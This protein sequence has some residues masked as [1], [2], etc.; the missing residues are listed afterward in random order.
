MA[1]VNKIA[2][3]VLAATT[4]IAT[5]AVGMIA[6]GSAM[7]SPSDAATI[8]VNGSVSG[9][10]FTAYKLAS[11]NNVTITDGK[12]QA[13]VASEANVKG[14]IAA[15]AKEANIKV[16]DGQDPVDAVARNA[17][18]TQVKA[19]AAAL[20]KA[21]L[22]SAGTADGKGSTATLNVTEGWYLVTDSKGLPILVG[23]KIKSGNQTATAMKDGTPLGTVNIKSTSL[24]VDKKVNGSDNGSASIGSTIGYTVTIPMPDPANVKTLQYKDT[25]TG[26]TI[27][28]A[29][30]ATIDGKGVT[31]TSQVNSGKSGFTVDLTNL[32]AGNKGKTLVISYHAKTTAETVTNDAQLSGTDT[33]GNPI[34]PDNGGG[35]DT[36]TVKAYNFDLTKVDA[37]STGTKLQGAQFKIQKKDGAWLK[38]AGGAWSD[39]KNEADATVFTTNAE[40]KTDFTGLGNGDYTVKEVTAPADHYLAGT[41][42]FQATVKNGTTTFSGNSLVS[43]ID[44]DSAQVK[45]N[46]TVNGLA[47]TGQGGLLLAGSA[48]AAMAAIGLGCALAYKRQQAKA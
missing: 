8:T 24:S 41:F 25:L 19:F 3:G 48:A 7:A 38:Q 23:T 6:A 42:T 11:F 34:T 32:L 29:P 1:S 46:P 16:A 36:S 44:G 5:P 39:A 18:A 15:A 9:H 43:A 22:T 47:K 12:A 2:A 30:T 13:S 35:K 17:N 28:D 10:H 14:K 21:G 26:G 20:A 4:L 33:D 37:V 40:G 27:T 31:I 45:N